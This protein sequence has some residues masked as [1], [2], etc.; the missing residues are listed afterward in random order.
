MTRQKHNFRTVKEDRSQGGMKGARESVP[1]SWNDAFPLSSNHRKINHDNE[2]WRH[3]MNGWCCEQT[4]MR[5]L[6][7]NS[8]RY[9]SCR[10]EATKCDAPLLP[11][12]LLK[13]YAGVWGFDPRTRSPRKVN[14]HTI[15]VRAVKPKRFSH[16]CTALVLL[17]QAPVNWGILRP[18]KMNGT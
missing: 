17:I 18:K 10:A 8:W 1:Y 4:K 12:I 6:N 14:V 16:F 7:Q 13:Y 2:I 15:V 3:T 11:S 5:A 9:C